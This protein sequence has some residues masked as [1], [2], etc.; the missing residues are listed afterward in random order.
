MDINDV[1]KIY[2]A[3][4]A[5][6]G[7]QAYKYISETL[8]E[9]KDLHRASFNGED[10]EQSWKGVK[11]NALETLI[12]YMINDEVE[13][14]GL[15]IVKGKKFER[16]KPENLSTELKHVKKNLAVDFGE[17]GFHIPDVDLVIYDPGSHKVVAVLSSKVTLRERIAQTAY[18]K[19]KM[20]NYELT[21]HIRV[22]FLTPDEDGTL[23]YRTP[24]KKGRAIVE[25]D[26]DGS[27]ILSV[28]DIEESDKV[29]T[30]DK[31]IQDLKDLLR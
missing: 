2:E 24:M 3:K 9:A 12:M 23:T 7:P 29:K 19:L 26:T 10:V 25:S 18:W 28:K 11:G 21:R 22:F 5:K 14:M 15:K 16:T 20:K 17:F 31:F 27:Y 8:R 6:Y 30:F 13:S 4:K 1:I